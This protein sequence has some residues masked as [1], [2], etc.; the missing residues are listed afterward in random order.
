MLSWKL[1]EEGQLDSALVL[2][3]DALELIRTS[4]ENRRAVSVSVQVGMILLREGQLDSASRY[5]QRSITIADHSHRAENIVAGMLMHAR[6]Q[7]GVREARDLNPVIEEYVHL[8]W[9]GYRAQHPGTRVEFEFVPDRELGA[10]EMIPQEIA[11]DS[12]DADIAAGTTHILLTAEL[13]EGGRTVVDRRLLPVP[14]P[15][16]GVETVTPVPASA[17]LDQNY[18][19]PFRGAT[20][21]SFGLDR[22]MPITLVVRDVLGREVRRLLDDELR[23]AGAHAMHFD[24][25]GMPPG[26]YFYH[27][28]GAGRTLTRRMLLL[29]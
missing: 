20:T 27:L 15:T 2:C 29:R 23:P 19:N 12:L 6:S 26:V 25:A 1:M 7:A 14:Q 3:R 17:R 28:T 24:A 10:I 22:R 13:T 5:F 9:E 16:T 21:I 4:G 8:A 11:R 18:P